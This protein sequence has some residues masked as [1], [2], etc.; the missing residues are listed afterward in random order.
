MVVRF[1][2]AH[3]PDLWAFKSASS[4]L[5]Y[6]KPCRHVPAPRASFLF[7]L[8]VWG[9][10][11]SCNTYLFYQE[12]K[13]EL[14]YGKT[15]EGDSPGL[16]T[17]A[18]PQRMTPEPGT[19]HS[20]VTYVTCTFLGTHPELQSVPA[21]YQY[22]HR[23]RAGMST[24]G[25]LGT[26]SKSCSPNGKQSQDEESSNKPDLSTLLKAKLLVGWVLEFLNKFVQLSL[27]WTMANGLSLFLLLQWSRTLCIVFVHKKVS[28]Q[29]CSISMVHLSSNR[30][31]S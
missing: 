11:E 6:S 17:S 5:L 28:K 20:C 31:K 7:P 21:L 19:A 3:N 22:Q 23:E 26:A 1:H 15:Q 29:K 10:T 18:C 30:K 8:P 4:V 13:L 9:R 12:D 27:I 25:V 16:K 14:V 2:L 24:T